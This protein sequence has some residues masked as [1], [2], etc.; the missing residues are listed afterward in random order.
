MKLELKL[1]LGLRLGDT[2][3]AG[4]S[5]LLAG[6]TLIQMSKEPHR[7]RVGVEFGV[8]PSQ[9]TRDLGRYCR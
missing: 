2:T 3:M 1:M 9:V 8:A 5:S 7:I 6:T 4:F